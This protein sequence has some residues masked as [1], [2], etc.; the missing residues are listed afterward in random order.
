ME[1]DIFNRI[2]L[3]SNDLKMLA[4]MQD[5]IRKIEAFKESVPNVVFRTNTL[6]SVDNV[7]SFVI[8][9]SANPQDTII[10]T[11]DKDFVDLRIKD[12]GIF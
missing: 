3:N 2:S 7:D 1:E 11:S 12:G 9:T 5:F 10:Y 8:T 4:S 6:S